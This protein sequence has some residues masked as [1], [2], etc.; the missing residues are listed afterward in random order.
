MIMNR[1]FV[2][3]PLMRR[4]TIV[5][6]LLACLTGSLT[7]AVKKVYVADFLPI[8]R[9]P[10]DL[11]VSLTNEFELVLV[12]SQ[13][14]DVLERRTLD[15]LAQHARNEIHA[16]NV[17]ELGTGVIDVLRRQGAQGV[18]FGEVDDDAESGE[19]VV[20]VT[21]ENFDSQ[22]EWKRSISLKRGLRN[23]RESR[24]AALRRLLPNSNSLMATAPAPEG[25]ASLANA[26]AT[27]SSLRSALDSDNQREQAAAVLGYLAQIK[28]LTFVLQLPADVKRQYETASAD[29]QRLE[30]LFSRYPYVDFLQRQGFRL[31]VAFTND[32]SNRG[33]VSSTVHGRASQGT[34][35]VTGDRVNGALHANLLRR[36]FRPTVFDSPINYADVACSFDFRPLRDRN[37]LLVWKGILACQSWGDVAIP[38]IGI[39]TDPF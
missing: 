31:N 32:G 9:V 5:A 35:T 33:V 30:Q 24:L 11:L 13:R 4:V 10:D 14:Y 6:F 1:E 3:W 22:K 25:D 36:G 12:E 20:Y 39:S 19:L 8:R 23:D 2:Y 29:P 18:I 34:F 7:A 38:R 37:E 16:S 27:I 21:L 28:E 26:P 15:R 17:R